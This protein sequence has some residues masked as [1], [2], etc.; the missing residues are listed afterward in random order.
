MGPS[1]SRREG[2]WTAAN[3]QPPFVGRRPERDALLN[4]LEAA[5]EGR[6][7]LYLISGEQGIGKTRLAAT[8]AEDAARRGDTILWGS[9]WEAGG[10][11]AYWPW[12]QVVRGLLQERPVAEVRED[13]GS[14]APY[15]AHIA[16][17]VAER[18]GVVE[19]VTALDTP[20]ALFSA[21]D[22]IASFRG[23]A[24]RRNPLLVVIDDLHAADVATLRLLEFLAGSLRGTR[25]LAIGTYRV[26]AGRAHA[27]VAAAL[28]DLRKAGERM[29]LIGLAPDEVAEIAAARAPSSPPEGLVK[30]LHALTE[31]N[32]LFVDEVMRLLIS[33]G[34]LAAGAGAFPSRL[35]LPEGVRETIR[36]RLDPLSADTAW[37]LATAAVIGPEFRME[38]LALTAGVDRASLIEQLDLATEAG[39]V[40]QVPGALGR[41][42]FTQGIVRETL[43]EG[44]SAR[45][46][47]TLHAAVG[48]ALLELHGDGPD[49]P[50]SE[51]A[52]HFL[53]AAPAG[54]PER[55]AD[56]AARA[57][58]RA[59]Q[60]LAYEQAIEFFGDALRALELQPLDPERRGA[61]LLAMGSAQMRAGRLAAGR[62]TLGQAAEL[63]RRAGSSDRLAR[64]ALASAPWGLAT[65][66]NDEEGLVPLLDEALA[67]LPEA[68]GALRAQLL[69]R[70]AA[71]TYWSASL[72]TRLALVS[73]AIAMARR[74]GEPETLAIVLSDA[75]RAT[76]DPDSPE[77]ALPWA[78]EIYALAE[79]VGNVELALTAHSWRI[80]LLLELG[81]L[82]VVEH[83]IQIFASSAG[84]LHQ[85]RAQVSAH[86]HACA[87][88]L[89]DGRYDDAERLLGSAAD[90][91]GLLQQDQFLVMR[92][93][94]LAFV[95][96][97]AQGRLGELE[98]AVR[99]FADAQPAMPVWRCGLVCV[100]LQTGREDEL[101]REYES[102]A[103]GDFGTLP[104][105]NLWLPSLAFL[106]EACA[107][108]RDEHGARALG[109]LLAP[110]A[111]RNVV[112]PD[113]A[114]V[115]PVDRYLA[116][117]AATAGD[118]AQAAARFAAARALAREMG[119]RPMCAQLALD[120]AQVLGDSDPARR[121]ALAA[122]AAEE[123]Q[124]LGLERVAAQAR[125]LA[126]D[127]P[128]VET[129][130]VP[131][132]PRAG[133]VRRRGDVWEVTWRGAPFHVKDAKGLHYLVRLLARPGQELHAL[134]LAGGVA[135]SAPEAAAVGP[136]L[137]VRGRGQDD[138]GPMLDAR[139]K[140]EY[141]RRIADL[142]EEIDE[143]EAFNVIARATRAREELEF[144][145]HELSAAVGLGGRDRR[146]AAA[147]ERARVNVTRAL[148]AT[149]D[150]IAGHDR[151]LGH[152]LRTCVR[153]G[154]F[155]VYEP[156]PDATAWEIDDAR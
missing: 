130:A 9:A 82:A 72:E 144:I 71:A 52:H 85:P 40:E 68:D 135:A 63:A 109:A 87:R 143:A 74:V 108:L 70:L 94:A 21:F 119:A 17:E 93:S 11:P 104:R 36:R 18:V 90:H 77:R 91:A 57:G 13:L 116:L 111:G 39:L 131:A 6:G 59:L 62:D 56:F 142:R 126:G 133:R 33:E 113:V 58:E 61:I 19:P 147:S 154:T 24:A 106:S 88:A 84:Q 27:D 66:L 16:P 101:R 145:G 153:T 76:W 7:A 53:E 10:A 99:Q 89:I 29:R 12:T 95:M 43:Y 112:T 30:R 48:E 128:A 37:L 75:H 35:P 151:A 120:E 152:H 22:A 42:R 32:P 51:L 23:A 100:Y 156:G 115:G 129:P 78:S 121:A 25:I 54:E 138:A 46:R 83:E 132:A 97:Y 155:C 118:H 5:G 79:R 137:S 146:A 140:A 47:L 44:L 49:A 80:S 31:G 28:A 3:A 127:A 124:A 136:E 125:E 110:Y 60:T 67:Q 148:R 38:T 92:L 96:R 50:F 123:A 1:V 55:A 150:R 69:A 26:G 98:P 41:Y 117:V 114:Y 139:A 45:E 134:D 105:D 14:A 103:E 34:A 2:E 8:L 81:Q 102:L 141:G 65:G 107:H 64:V 122:Q 86:V 15:L 73:E 4:A 149:V 20:A